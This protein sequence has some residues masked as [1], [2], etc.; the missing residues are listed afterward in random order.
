MSRTIA[1][2]RVIAPHTKQYENEVTKISSNF[3]NYEIVNMLSAIIIDGVVIND[4]FYVDKIYHRKNNN[5][6]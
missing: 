4:S 3:R 6:K 2:L 1:T 5:I